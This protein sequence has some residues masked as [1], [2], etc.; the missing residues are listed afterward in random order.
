[1]FILFEM[2]LFWLVAKLEGPLAGVDALRDLKVELI[3]RKEVFQFPTYHTLH[4][5]YIFNLKTKTIFIML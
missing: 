1:M 4:T 2:F 5:T 3:S